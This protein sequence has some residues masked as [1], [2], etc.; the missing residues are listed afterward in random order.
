MYLPK[1]EVCVCEESK[2]YQDLNLDTFSSFVLVFFSPLS[3][4][5]LSLLLNFPR[6]NPFCRVYHG[7]RLNLGKSSEMITNFWVT[8]EACNISGG[9][10]FISK[11]CPEPKPNQLTKFSFIQLL[12]HRK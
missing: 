7:F 2:E 11:N 4:E 3:F 9:S 12:K 6:A 8:F 10:L 1:M 5:P